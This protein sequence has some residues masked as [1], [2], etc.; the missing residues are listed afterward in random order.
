MSFKLML[1]RKEDKKPNYDQFDLNYEIPSIS[2]KHKKITSHKFSNLPARA[3]ISLKSICRT[4]LYNTN[5]LE[6]YIYF[7][8]NRFSL[9][10]RITNILK[11][12]KF[13]CKKDLIFRIIW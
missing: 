12:T 9:F 8:G 2:T 10:L 1:P 4:E 13:T 5:V 6:S 11:L 7:T 3:P